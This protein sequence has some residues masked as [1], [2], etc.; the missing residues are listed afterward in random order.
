MESVERFYSNGKLL[1]TGEYLVLSGA[2]ALS[3][4]CRYGQY[5]YIHKNFEEDGRILDWTANV[6]GK[7]WFRCRIDP[8]TWVAEA[9]PERE[10]LYDGEIAAGLVKIIRAASEIKQ[11][12]D[13]LTGV[14]AISEIG[15]ELKWGLGSSSSL[16]SNIAWWGEVDPFRINQMVSTGSGY[17]IASARHSSPILYHKVSGLPGISEIQ[18]DPPFAD[19][20]AFIYLGKKQNSAEGVK[21]FLNN[22]LV[23][24]EDINKISDI[25]LR[26]SRA[27]DLDEYE[28][29]LNEHEL[30][31][32]G[33]LDRPPVKYA[34]F[35]DYPG[36][37]KSLGDWGG[38]FAHISIR[39]EM[40]EVK[41]YF[42]ERGFKQIIPY[43]ELIK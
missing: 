37:V 4:P 38:D 40:D 32:S 23:R 10:E 16:I 18:F 33:I 35:P 21:N 28:D 15:F 41:A 22:A 29:L 31:M 11:N 14:R 6:K 43:R 39:Q 2:L 7:P 19:R 27:S 12:K 13:W 20:L 1:L 34:L 25:T 30:I 9:V 42:R 5:L 24:E 8:E 26:V 36:T 17:D 3:L